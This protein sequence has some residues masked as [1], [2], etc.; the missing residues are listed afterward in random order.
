MFT[1]ERRYAEEFAIGLEGMGMPR[2]YG[3]LL[4]W[5]LVC[6]PPQQSSAELAG[7]LDL[8]KGSVSAGT[9]LLVNAGLIR[10]VAAPGQRG[11]AYEVTPNA[12]IKAV[13]NNPYQAFLDLLERGLGVVGGDDLE[14]GARL[15]HSRD[16]MAFV[17]R[18]MPLLVARFE[19]EHGEE[20]S[21]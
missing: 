4:G 19:A 18:E 11:N 12:M 5:L 14:R 16:F 21:G 8:S 7:A 15:R 20:S 13:Q 3:K 1:P 2:A 9:R 10:R 6:D 17:V